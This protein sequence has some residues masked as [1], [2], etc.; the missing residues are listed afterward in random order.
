MT[1]FVYFLKT[2]EEQPRQALRPICHSGRHRLW[3]PG[4]VVLSLVLVS[5]C[6]LASA[7]TRSDV[8]VLYLR[9][10][11]FFAGRLEDCD[12]TNTVRWRAL[13]A[14]QPFEFPAGAIRTAYLPTSPSPPTPVDSYRF[15]LSNGD[16]LSGTLLGI[17]AE[18]VDIQSAELGALQLSRSEILRVITLGAASSSDY[19][20]LNGIA[21]W[22]TSGDKQWTDEAGRFFTNTRGAEI[23]KELVIPERARIEFEIA[24][25]TA[26]EFAL[27]LATGAS[28]EQLQAG[29]R[30]EVWD[31]KLV[32]VRSGKVEAD[33][34]SV[35][36]L[37]TTADHIHLEAYYDQDSGTLAVRSLDGKQ[38]AA[39]TAPKR[40]RGPLRLVSLTNIGSDVRL[41]QLTI[42]R[43]LGQ[44]PAPA[45]VEKARV[46]LTDGTTIS[47]DE[48]SY[49]PERKQFVV[50]V[51][52][53]EKQIEADRVSCI[54]FP[55]APTPQPVGG[56]FGMELND[57]SRVSGDIS[58]I[59]NGKLYMTRRGLNAP[60]I[61]A[62][63]NLRSIAGLGADF[64]SSDVRG[65]PGRLELE[66]V[67]SHGTLADS[68]AVDGERDNL[69]W[70]PRSSMTSSPLDKSASGRI[71]YRDPPRASFKLT[72]REQELQR[73]RR[74]QPFLGVAG[75]A[76]RFENH[77]EATFQ[78][79][80]PR[81]H[82]AAT[83]YLLAGD[84]IPC[85]VSAIDEEGVYFESPVVA[86]NF[87][88]HSGL[89]ALEFAPDWTAAALNDVERQRL[90]TLPRMQKGNP[91]TH[92]VVST[93]GDYLRTK[94]TAMTVDKL[95]IESHLESKEIPRD[96][97][98]CV[99]WLHDANEPPIPG[100]LGSSQ[101]VA[102][103][104]MDG[105]RVQAVQTDGVRLT[106][107]TQQCTGK[108]LSGMSQLLG[109]C[110][111]DLDKVDAIL[112]GKVIGGEAIEQRFQLWKLTE[113]VEP[114]YIGDS[115]SGGSKDRTSEAESTLVGKK[116]PDIRLEL[117]E[118]KRF[119]LAEHKGHVLVLDFW[120]SWCGP[121]MQAMPQV[122]SVV[123]EFSSRGVK[124]V[125]VNMQEDRAAASSALDRLK[126]HPAVALDTDGAAAEHYQVTAIPETVVIDAEGNI[127]KILIGSNPE[128]SA[129][130]RSAIEQALL[131][132]NPH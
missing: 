129:Q 52:S 42:G 79:V 107:V 123:N 70:Q 98:A 100:P 15:E 6:R 80:K 35:C 97:V 124:L 102:K 106:F 11:D 53:E 108:T 50:Q 32:L 33:V 36:A 45:D 19:R 28:A 86:C 88:P 72:Q 13:G 76:V 9:G 114:R 117:L 60:L 103:E 74:R 3:S 132:P 69:I 23:H 22:H 109:A 39:V 25:D 112:F 119:D 125:A 12:K 41:D 57:G 81:P 127:A 113:A 34:A 93:T 4:R 17:S 84:R 104:Q 121:C 64:H 49:E 20:G 68:T 90:L 110:H 99:I 71:I 115:A 26:P 111:V 27:V 2:G 92:L 77:R 67:S 47:A 94:L 48:I 87:L 56:S 29:Y 43:W 58:K 73:L 131:P 75:G 37:N 7:V 78:P 59:V 116:A 126:V 101:S 118:G 105:L 18:W 24:W 21:A 83:L 40:D 128:F 96:R 46:Q 1:M 10:G 65:R 54:T 51:D 82:G 95:M 85:E 30:F 122:D 120:A 55:A 130:L 31:H 44:Q 16:V 5:C 8:S 62:I 66:G 63:S 91:P 38:L 14:T 89:K 61:C